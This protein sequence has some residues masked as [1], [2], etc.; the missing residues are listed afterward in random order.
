MPK[1]KDA[2]PKRTFLRAKT[3][4]LH[5]K[6]YGFT[7]KELWFCTS[8]TMF[9]QPKNYAFFSIHQVYPF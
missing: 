7:A 3:M 4:L 8:K 1:C 6:A 9:L 2:L 5:F